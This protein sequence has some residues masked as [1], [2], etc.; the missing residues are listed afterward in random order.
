MKRRPLL[1]LAALLIPSLIL[2]PAAVA[3]ASPGSNTPCSS[4]HDLD[5]G[6]QVT[7][8]LVS[9]TAL[10]TVYALAVNNP[11]GNN[12]WAVFQ[13]STKVAGASGSGSTVTLSNGV[14]YTL[15]GVSGNGYASLQVTPVAPTPNPNP[16]PDVTAPTTASNAQATYTGSASIR[17]TAT[18]NVG[19]SGVAHTYY[20][21]DGAA[22]T[23]GTTVGTSVLGA[24]SL[25]FWSVDVSGN[26]ESP[27]KTVSF[28]VT[29]APAVQSYTYTYKFKLKK[30][31]YK[32]AKAT[33]RSQAT[34][35][36]Y[37]VRISKRGVASFRSI[38]GGRYRL[39]ASGSA[40]FKFK[41]RTVWVGPKPPHKAHH[42]D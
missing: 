1:L 37:T 28:T 2:G 38:P 34:G 25:E 35:R 24:H 27:H 16:G 10:Q 17:L 21:L 40:R 36:K 23:E 18:D 32:R 6:V 5:A 8:T 13:G 9:A 7:A 15:Y 30:N 42:D 3:N 33:L 20:V 22:Q 11:N 31:Q 19:G 41:A 39:S 4:C 14:T 26:V 29:A 12:G